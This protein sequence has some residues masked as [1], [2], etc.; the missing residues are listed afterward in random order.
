MKTLQTLLATAVVMAAGCVVVSDGDGEEA[1]ADTGSAEAT[2]DGADLPPANDA[3]GDDDGDDDGATDDD[4]EADDDAQVDDSTGGGATSSGG[5]GGT[6]TGFADTGFTETGDPSGDSGDGASSS[7]DGSAVA[8]SFD[9][10]V[11]PII[12]ENCG[13]HR[14]ASPSAGL[15]MTD[16]AAYES[17]V[18]QPSSNGLPYVTPGDPDESYI[19]HKL[20]GT[21]VA[22]GG[23][24]NQMP[25]G[26]DLSNAD[27]AT[28]VQWIADGAQ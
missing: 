26:G 17:L 11:L 18:G 16:D 28:I 15:D 8:L 9:S 3:D 13:C 5:D 23:G 6:D 2:D 21:Q 14:S 20:E 4:A 12:A 19:A 27:V 22:A 10:D 7:D 24:G 1:A 25:L